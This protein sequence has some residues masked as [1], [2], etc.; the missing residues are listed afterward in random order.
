[1]Y[2]Q[3]YIHTGMSES[4]V[5]E[6]RSILAQLHYTYHVWEWN[7]QG[8]P[9]CTHAYVPET[10]PITGEEFHEREEGILAVYLCY[11]QILTTFFLQQ[12]IAMC[13]RE[14]R[15]PNINLERYQEALNIQN[16]N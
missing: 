4:P 15:N 7:R 12:R 8:V 13:T 16:H 14:G 3:L 11:L 1:M 5:D 10:D 9:F 2:T 6:L